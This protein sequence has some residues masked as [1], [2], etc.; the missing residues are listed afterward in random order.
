M[1]IIIVVV[2]GLEVNAYPPA[3]RVAKIM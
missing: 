3:L 2:A 1:M